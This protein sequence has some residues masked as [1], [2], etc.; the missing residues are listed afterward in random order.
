MVTINE[1]VE[2][3]RSAEAN[4]VEQQGFKTFGGSD[5]GTRYSALMFQP[6]LIGVL[7][8]IGALTQS[9]P[10]FL[11]LGLIVWWSALVPLLSPFDAIYNFL[12]A[13]PR[14]LP[15]LPPAPS[16]R[17]FAQGMA[18][19]FM[20]AIALFLAMKVW[21]L[22]WILEALLLAALAALIFWKFCLGSYV[23]HVLRGK[24]AF[25]NRTLP[26]VRGA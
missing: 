19:S 4:F 20:L 1:E 10:L 15:S 26:W 5:C 18:G 13:G 23:F 6:R 25:A 24:A 2:M 8:A 21:V 3:T 9:W 17:R 16:P 14:R 11:V 12:V 7:V 22:A